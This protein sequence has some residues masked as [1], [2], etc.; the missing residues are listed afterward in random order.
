MS[1]FGVCH[2]L[3]ES[4]ILTGMINV[5][6]VLGVLLVAAL[7]AILVFRLTDRLDR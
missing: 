2:G 5:L 6:I 7:F 1:N 4:A 3:P